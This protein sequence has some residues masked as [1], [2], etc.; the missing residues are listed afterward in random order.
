MIIVGFL[1]KK[2]R[3]VPWAP[4]LQ[5]KDIFFYNKNGILEA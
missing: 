4:I 2:Q 5:I 1:G 3:D